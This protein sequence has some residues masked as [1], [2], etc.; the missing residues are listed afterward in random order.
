MAARLCVRT[1]PPCLSKERRDEDATGFYLIL[2]VPAF[3]GTRLCARLRLVRSVPGGQRFQRIA[4][5]AFDPG[6]PCGLRPVCVR[7]FRDS[8]PI[9]HL[10]HKL[11]PCE[12]GGVKG[13]LGKIASTCEAA[14]EPYRFHW[15][16]WQQ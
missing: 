16:R 15:H 4:V 13:W 5:R 1:A 7:K 11:L 9:R 10:H 8:T 3:S 2:V 12:S 14:Q 6:W